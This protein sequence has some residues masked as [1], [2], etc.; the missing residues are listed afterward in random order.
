MLRYASACSRSIAPLPGA[1]AG[2]AGSVSS[3]GRRASARSTALTNPAALVLRAL[4][5]SATASSTA[6]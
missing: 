1:A 3:G 4:R 5:A 2:R 6:A